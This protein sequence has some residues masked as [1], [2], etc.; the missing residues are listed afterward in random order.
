M[1]NTGSSGWNNT[2][3]F[4][5]WELYWLA[6]ALACCFPVK[7]QLRSP[8]SGSNV[9]SASSV[10]TVGVFHKLCVYCRG[11]WVRVDDLKNCMCRENYIFVRFAGQSLT[12]CRKSHCCF[13]IFCG[14]W[15]SWEK[16]SSEITYSD[17]KNLTLILTWMTFPSHLTLWHKEIWG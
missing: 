16:G 17:I 5:L 15:N 13:D 3:L 14:N 6:N 8:S 9:Y 12:L 1:A 7:S 10:S 2:G 4:S 11:F